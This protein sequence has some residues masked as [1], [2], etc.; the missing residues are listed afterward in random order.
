MPLARLRAR[1]KERG[2]TPAVSLATSSCLGPCDV[3][4]VA[5]II[6]ADGT[7]WLGGLGHADYELLAIWAESCAH[8]LVPLPA[9]LAVKQFQRWQATLC[10]AAQQP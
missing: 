3:A 6:R 9:E 8:G 10:A 1:W 5:C 4:N 7:W 2:L